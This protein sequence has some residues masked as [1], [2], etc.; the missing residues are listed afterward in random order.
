[1]GRLNLARWPKIVIA[2]KGWGRLLIFMLD[3][4][5][6]VRLYSEWTRKYHILLSTMDIILMT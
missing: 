2:P 6:V 3:L 1:M 5:T 4:G